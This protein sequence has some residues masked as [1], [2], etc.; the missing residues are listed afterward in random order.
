MEN[1]V[2]IHFHCNLQ[3]SIIL[4]LQCPTCGEQQDLPITDVDS[5]IGFIC[6]CGEDIPIHAEALKPVA[7]ELEELRHL[8]QRTI[9]LPI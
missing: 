7:H 8:I 9:V 2:K 5:G 1:P 6:K 3:G 4:A